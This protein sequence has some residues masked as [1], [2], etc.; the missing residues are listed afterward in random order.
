MRKTLSIALIALIIFSSFPLIV[1]HAHAEPAS[2]GAFL[3]AGGSDPGVVYKYSGTDW[4][5]ISSELGYAVLCLVEYDGHLY[6]GTTSAFSSGGIGRVYR[7][8]GGTTWTLVGDN[9]DN[10]VCSLAVYEGNLYAGTAWNGMKLYRYDGGT[11]W[12]QVIGSITWAGTR[13]LYVS[14]GYLLL[15]DVLY[16]R[17]GRWDGS[18]FYADQSGGGSCIY[19][20][21]DFGDYVY[22]AAYQGR[23]WRST[24]AIHWSTVLGYYDG[25]MWELEEFQNKLYMSYNNGEL[26]AYDGTGDLRGTL[27]YT[28]PDGIISMITDGNYLYFGTGGDA[29]GYGP[30]S[31]GIASV[32]RYDGTSVIRISDQDEMVTGVQVLYSPEVVQGLIEDSTPEAYVALGTLRHLLLAKGI[33]PT[34]LS[35]PITTDLL[36][37]C[38]ILVITGLTVAYGYGQSYSTSEISAVKEW[39]SNGGSLLLYGDIN[40][41]HL[42]NTLSHEFGIDFQQ[43]VVRDPTNNYLGN[44]RNPLIHIFSDHSITYGISQVV[45]ASGSSMLVSTPVV[46]L[47]FTD[48]DSTPA[49]SPVLA[50]AKFEAGKVVATGDGNAINDWGVQTPFDNMKLLTNIVDWLTMGRGCWII[51]AGWRCDRALQ[52]NINYGCNEV[53]QILRNGGYSADNIYYLSPDSPQDADGDGT[54]DVDATISSANLQWA[55]ETW[56]SSRVGP[57]EPLWL[58]L[59]SHGGTDEFT[60]CHDDVTATQLETWYTTLEAVTGAPIYT[61]YAACHSGSFID[62]LSEGERFIATSCRAEE[63]SAVD[64]SGNWEYFSA[65]F[66]R[67]IQS[68]HSVG[69]SFNRACEVLEDRPWWQKLPWPIGWQQHP[70]LDDNGDETGHTGPLPDGGDGDLTFRLHITRS[71]WVYPWIRNVIAKQYFTWPPPSTVTLWAEVEN[72][73]SLSNVRACMIPPDWSP[74]PSEDVLLDLEFEYFEMSDPDSDGNFTVH[75]PAASFAAHAVGPSEFTFIVT[76]EEENGMIAIPLATGVEFIETFPPPPDSTPPRV[77][78][79]RPLEWQI[80]RGQIR[81]NGTATDD[82]CLQRVELLVEGTLAGAMNMLP[83]SNG[84]FSFDLDVS[85]IPNGPRSILVRAFDTTGNSG[86]QTLTILVNNP[87]LDDTYPVTTLLIGEPK[88]LDTEGNIYVSSS[89]L[90]TLIAEDNIGGSDVAYSSYRVYDASYDTG[91]LTYT[92]P[93]NLLGPV[94]GPIRID[95][96]STDFAGNVESTNTQPVILDNTAPVITDT[97]FEGLALQD[98]VTFEVSAW[99]LSE[100]ASVTFSIQCEQGDMVASGSATLSPE[101][102]WKWDFDTTLH[103]D[104]YYFAVVT[105]TDVLGN[106]GDTPVPFSV[107]NWACVELLPASESNKGGRTMPVKFSLRVVEA[108]DP[109]QPFVYN[110]ELT[111]LIYEKDHPENILQNSTYGDTARDY[112]I[113]SENEH[114][115]TN[116]KTLKRPTRY[117]VE[118]WRKGMLIGTFDFRTVK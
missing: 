99:D 82:V 45:F 92:E 39:V 6:A 65:T 15:G 35:R 84:F 78:I 33:T 87:P 77:D 36:Q 4:E 60:I 112:R 94:D 24:D 63:D 117:V 62:E 66:W 95:Y 80:T 48:E 22:A 88:Y 18:N 25:N 116:F 19:D 46:A 28:A 20:Y 52:A 68:G 109:A 1:G 43:N 14:H 38:K 21:Q 10:E 106:T 104:G 81:V 17:F 41:W 32:Y 9:M 42:L 110:E 54:N 59:F 29:V 16:D 108:V 34:T 64:P 90:F 71:E 98:G 11:T 96:R 49:N 73:T 3:Y 97:N 47:G 86:S 13:S 76:A 111:I 44:P 113:N 61:I 67:Q 72:D 8:D 93:F 74:P 26:R 75:I 30:E 57:T 69:W 12:T 100:V 7:Y 50:Y 23:L 70:L 55:I 105:A 5:V 83:V 27:V 37:G 31:S 107:R 118:V 103:P 53:F 91:W 115:I 56:A 89:T 101:G 58:Y 102:K 79:E 2:N 51:A 114:Y 40:A 85:T